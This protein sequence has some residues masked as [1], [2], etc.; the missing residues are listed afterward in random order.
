MFL[1]LEL[2]LSVCQH[3]LLEG[4][5]GILQGFYILNKEKRKDRLWAPLC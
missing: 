4:F 1:G 5:A 3:D 2:H